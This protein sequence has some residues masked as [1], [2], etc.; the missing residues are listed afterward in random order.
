MR[1]SEDECRSLLRCAC[2][3]MDGY[4][5]SSVD[6]CLVINNCFEKL[7]DNQRMVY[8]S[9]V[10]KNMTYSKIGDKLGKSAS[11]AR[12]ICET[13]KRRIRWQYCYPNGKEVETVTMETS[14]RLLGM[15]TY[16][17]TALYWSKH[18]TIKDLINLTAEDLLDIN[19]IG[20]KGVE[21]IKSMLQSHGLSLKESEP[22]I[23]TEIK[24]VVNNEESYE[25]DSKS[26]EGLYKRCKNR[27]SR[28][29]TY[30]ACIGCPYKG[31]GDTQCIF[32]TQP[33]TWDVKEIE[34]IKS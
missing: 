23:L 28:F 18:R 22:I 8:E 30:G 7:T 21:T 3:D 6:V 32:K 16:L 29:G 19:G 27:T 33:R 12:Q 10:L 26:I 11:R 1:Y 20:L 34:V 9:Y 15:P 13:V 5:E 2:K 25:V 24:Y 17:G 14:V 4:N 31:Y